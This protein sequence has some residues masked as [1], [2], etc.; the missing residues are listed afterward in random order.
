MPA[1]WQW[2]I[3]LAIVLLA[4]AATGS[5]MLTRRYFSAR[6]RIV[7]ET[8][9]L[10][11]FVREDRRNDGIEREEEV[12]LTA[13]LQK[14]V[15]R[16][17]AK[18]ASDLEERI[19][20]RER[21]ALRADAKTAEAKRAEAKR[22]S[23]AIDLAVAEGAISL[24]EYRSARVFKGR[25]TVIFGL[26]VALGV[27]GLFLVGDWSRGERDRITAWTTCQKETPDAVQDK[28]C[29]HLD[30][31]RLPNFGAPSSPSAPSP[32]PSS[33]PDAVIIRLNECNAV[34]ASPGVPTRLR[35]SALAACAGLP[36]PAGSSTATPGG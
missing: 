25:R 36:N 30:P 9:V 7:V 20:Q 35:E 17:K 18:T 1:G 8:S 33:S 27:G 10:V 31:R 24:L 28:I 16:E 2:L 15:A 19:A 4:V 34:P 6:R 3:V 23:D 14:L 32:T 13:P 11:P 5:A 21:E 22:L 29:A 12:F 26:M